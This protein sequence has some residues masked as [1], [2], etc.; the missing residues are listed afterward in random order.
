MTKPTEPLLL[1]IEEAG[2]VLGLGRTRM[3]AL[4]ASGDLPAVR[5]G[6][7]IRIPSDELRQWIN[8]RIK[9]G[10][11]AQKPPKPGQTVHADRKD[12]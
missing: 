2:R 9:V 11:K 1:N 8:T 12:K 5:I 6:G 7:S 3:Y 4:V 10:R